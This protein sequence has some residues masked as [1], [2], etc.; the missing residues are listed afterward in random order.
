[1][2]YELE[3]S[4]GDGEEKNRAIAKRLKPTGLVYNALWM[5]PVRPGEG[6]MTCALLDWLLVV[7]S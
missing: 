7:M 2:Q 6:D 5:Y 4:N 1:M 3:H